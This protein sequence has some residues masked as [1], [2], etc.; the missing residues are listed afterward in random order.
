MPGSMRTSAPSGAA[1]NAACSEGKGR[2]SDP[3]G[4]CPGWTLASCRTDNTTVGSSRFSS[5]REG[6][7]PDPP[8]NASSAANRRADRL[9]VIDELR[10]LLPR[11]RVEP[12]QHQLVCAQGRSLFVVRAPARP[13]AAHASDGDVRLAGRDVRERVLQELPELF[14]HASEGTPTS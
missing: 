2:A 1:A 11:E 14:L 6:V 10:E 7:S 8:N 3:S 13:L 9:Q 12:R 4:G 5:A